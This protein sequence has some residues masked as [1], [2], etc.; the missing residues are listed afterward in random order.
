MVKPHFI[1]KNNMNKSSVR[2]IYMKDIL[3][4]D[5]LRDVCTRITGQIS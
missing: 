2:H 4:H 5:I 3:T 1:I